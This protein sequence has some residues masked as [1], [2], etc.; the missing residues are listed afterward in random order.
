MN[1]AKNRFATVLYLVF[2]TG[3]ILSKT[4]KTE[5]IF[6]DFKNPGLRVTTLAPPVPFRNA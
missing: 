4:V 1:R 3:L 5:P 6:V 2:K